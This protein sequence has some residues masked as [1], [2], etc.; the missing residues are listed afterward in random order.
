M[1][2][3]YPLYS[4]LSSMFLKNT[5]SYTVTPFL[6]NKIKYILEENENLY[7][8]VKHLDIDAELD[9]VNSII[10]YLD[11]K[12]ISKPEKIALKNLINSIREFEEILSEL[13]Q[14]IE[15][16]KQLWFSNWRNKN[17]LKKIENLEIKWKILKSRTSRLSETIEMIS[18]IKK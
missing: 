1:E 14:D 3:I 7:E 9:V 2:N 17:Y 16:H 12:K 18:F 6:N 13:H 5:I 8:L 15:L 11:K 4:I 10:K